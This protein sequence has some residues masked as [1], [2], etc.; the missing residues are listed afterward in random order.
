MK[1][2]HDKKAVRKSEFDF[3]TPEGKRAYSK[4]RYKLKKELFLKAITN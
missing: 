3:K 1:F 2:L 4:D